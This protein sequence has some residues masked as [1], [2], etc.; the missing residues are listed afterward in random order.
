[1]IVFVWPIVSIFNA[2]P[3]GHAEVDSEPI[4]TA[5]LKEHAL[6]ARRRS[7]EALADQIFAQRL[8]ACSTKNPVSRVQIEIDILVTAVGIPLFAKPFDLGQLW[9]R[10]GYASDSLDQ[11]WIAISDLS[12]VAER[13]VKSVGEAAYRLTSVRAAQAFFGAADPPSPGK[14]VA[15]LRA[16]AAC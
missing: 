3:A 4:V 16:C 5:K 14:P 2:D 9:H 10:A 8:C 1:M 7:K 13:D 6:P 12:A 15:P 11:R